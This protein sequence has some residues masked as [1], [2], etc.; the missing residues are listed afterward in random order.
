MGPAKLQSAG[1]PRAPMTHTIRHCGC[2]KNW[3]WQWQIDPS[4]PA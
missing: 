1:P 3:I 4:R 2:A